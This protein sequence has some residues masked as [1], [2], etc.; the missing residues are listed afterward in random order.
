MVL[1]KKSL[2]QHFLVDKNI[3][4]KIIDAI[5]PSPSVILEIGPGTGVLTQHILNMEDVNAVFVETDQEAVEHLHNEF[6]SIAGRI[7][8]ADF[9]KVDLT[10]LMTG[11][12][13]VVGNL[14]YNISSQIFFRF[15]E[16]HDR[17][18]SAVV[19]IQKEV[20][21]RIRSAPGSKDYGILSVLLQT[22]YD[23]EYLFT[24]SEHVFHPPPRVKSAVIRLIRNER[25]DIECDPAFFTRVVKTAFNQRR[26]TL[27]NALKS[28]LKENVPEAISD[29]LSKRAEQLSVDE[30]IFLTRKLQP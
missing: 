15:L 9:L 4:R 28:L 26:K 29:L 18:R 8:H 19:M 20:A 21:E 6:P 2:G 25:T 30:F 16:D 23:I 13:K 3:A 24:V 1:P 22:W 17:M 10:E 5:P 11:P 12:Y 14:P 7:Y 27:R